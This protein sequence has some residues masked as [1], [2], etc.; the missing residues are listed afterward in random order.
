MTSKGQ[1][2]IPKDVRDELG[3]EPGVKIDFVRV[4]EREFRIRPKNLDVS[5]LFGILKYDGPPI[6][7]EEMNEAIRDGWAG[8]ER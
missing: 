2:T 3:L 8:I 1:I 4:S 6:T 7:I 5:A